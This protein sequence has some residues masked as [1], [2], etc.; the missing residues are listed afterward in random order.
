[1]KLPVNVKGVWIRRLAGSEQRHMEC[2][3]VGRAGAVILHQH[4]IDRLSVVDDAIRAHDPTSSCLSFGG[5]SHGY[6]RLV[7]SRPS[8]DTDKLVDHSCGG[9]ARSH[10]IQVR[11][12]PLG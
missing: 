8:C 5:F 4:F 1:M 10:R 9:M 3:G 6:D 7:G 11:K 12:E 2:S